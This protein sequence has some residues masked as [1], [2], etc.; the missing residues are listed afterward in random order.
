MEDAEA[1]FVLG[2]PVAPQPALPLG[3]PLEELLL[4]G[5]VFAEMPHPDSSANV[6]FAPK[7]KKKIFGMRRGPI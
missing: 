1:E 2:L 5:L 7:I 4:V 3:F 6:K